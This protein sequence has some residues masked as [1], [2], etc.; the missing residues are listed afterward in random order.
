MARYHAAYLVSG[1]VAALLIVCSASSAAWALLGA[2]VAGLLGGVALCL[3]W[4]STNVS[5]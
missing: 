1:V 4:Q 5:R 2:W 3:H